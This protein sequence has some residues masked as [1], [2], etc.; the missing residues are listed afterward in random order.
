MD[1]EHHRQGK[2]NDMSLFIGFLC[3]AANTH[4][5]QNYVSAQRGVTTDTFNVQSAQ[6]GGNKNNDNRKSPSELKKKRPSQRGYVF[7]YSVNTG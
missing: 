1:Q 7:L 6:A 4:F 2:Q 3:I 5:V